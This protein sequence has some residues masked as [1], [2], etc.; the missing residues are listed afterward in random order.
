MGRK[1]GITNKNVLQT[2][3]SPLSAEQLADIVRRWE[4]GEALTRIA[5]SY[6]MNYHTFWHY[7][8]KAR[9]GKQRGR[10]PSASKGTSKRDNPPA[11][12]DAQIALVVERWASGETLH[13][14]VKDFEGFT[15]AQLATLT[16][17]ERAKKR[18]EM[19]L[20]EA[21]LVDVMKRWE[22][23]ESLHSIA[24]SYTV[25]YL[26]IWQQT[27]P[28]REG[29]EGGKELTA[30][31]VADAIARRESGDTLASIAR[32]YGVTPLTLR[33]YMRRA[34]AKSVP[35]KVQQLLTGEQIQDAVLLWDQGATV[36]KIAKIYGIGRNK[37]QEVIIFGR[38]KR[39]D[40]IEQIAEWSKKGKRATQAV[41]RKY[42]ALGL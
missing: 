29:K 32:E 38:W 17:K 22:A 2:W 18:A 12:S 14:I 39:G 4:G 8:K 28:L 20:T 40:A 9:E 24:G 37:M 41:I 13:Q 21:E 11:L 3:L 36:I 33:T 15:Y 34:L 42:I 10:N 5:A 1:Y 26:T 23:G 25:P 30:Q 35:E 16:R 6:G 7:T 31:Q 19:L 27:K